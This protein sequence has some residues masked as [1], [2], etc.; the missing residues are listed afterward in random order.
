MLQDALHASR[1]R[2]NKGASHERKSN[3]AR[4]ESGTRKLLTASE[5]VVLEVSK[6]TATFAG[7][8]GPIRLYWTKNEQQPSTILLSTCTKILHLT[9]T[10]LPN[11]FF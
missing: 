8:L 1:E 10:E 5:K 2:R 6:K 4:F 11:P 7:L 3:I 9:A